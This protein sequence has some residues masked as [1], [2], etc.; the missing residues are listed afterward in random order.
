MARERGSNE[1]EFTFRSQIQFKGSAERFAR[2]TAALEELSVTMHP[3]WPPGHLAGCWPVN[4]M[5]VLGERV[6]NRF[7]EGM[8]RL[9]IVRGID[10]GI[11][12]PHFHVGDEV[13]LVSRDRFREAVEQVAGNLAGKL[14][15]GADYTETVG[16]LHHLLPQSR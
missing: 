14:A 15:G 6:F 11:W 1:P 4:P 12:D 16:A 13:V 10:G 2:L 8:P 3:D 7:T 5:E 9:K